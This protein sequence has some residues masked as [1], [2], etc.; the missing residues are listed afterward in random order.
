MGYSITRDHFKLNNALP[1]P[2]F[3][4]ALCFSVLFSFLFLSFPFLATRLLSSLLLWSPLL[5]P[6]FL[7]LLFL[8]WVPCGQSILSLWK[9][10]Y[11]CCGFPV[12][13]ASC[14]CDS[15]YTIYIYILTQALS[16]DHAVILTGACLAWSM[17]AMSIIHEPWIKNFLIV[18]KVKQ[19]SP[20]KSKYKSCMTIFRA[21]NRTLAYDVKV[22]QFGGQNKKIPI[23][24]ELESYCLVLKIELLS[25]V[26]Q[27]IH[28][29]L[30][31]WT[32]LTA[33]IYGIIDFSPSS[34]TFKLFRKSLHDVIKVHGQNAG[35]ILL[36]AG[37][38]NFGKWKIE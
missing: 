34:L 35:Q 13:K 11:L 37:K 19:E 14:Q 2:L 7:L 29:M 26:L 22:A 31:I 24:R 21:W 32:F 18:H 28:S 16:L 12:V 36:M 33:I 17:P 27:G 4:T 9:Y 20:Q 10:L 3:S 23:S 5:F 30:P 8:I 25:Y 1:C 38:N 6:L 15:I